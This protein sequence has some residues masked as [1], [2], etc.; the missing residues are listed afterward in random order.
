[1]RGIKIII[2]AKEGS[3]KNRAHLLEALKDIE[4]GLVEEHEQI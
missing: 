1:M 4:K 3:E 2:D